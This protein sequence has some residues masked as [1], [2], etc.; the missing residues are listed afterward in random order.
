MLFEA[1]PKFQLAYAHHAPIGVL[2]LEGNVIVTG[3]CGKRSEKRESSEFGQLTTTAA[4]IFRKE[5]H[6][7]RIS[8]CHMEEFMIQGDNEGL[9]LHKNNH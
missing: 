2:M 6:E 8:K 3:Q 4:Q 9:K 5:N 7:R 1:Y